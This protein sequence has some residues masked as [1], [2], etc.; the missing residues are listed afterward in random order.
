MG[1][2]MHTRTLALAIL[3]LAT[4][5]PPPHTPLPPTPP[6][7]P[8]PPT[9]TP[10]LTPIP[11]Q[12]MRL[13]AGEGVVSMMILSP[14]QAAALK[15]QHAALTADSGEEG[16]DGEGAQEETAEEEALGPEDNGPWL[17]IVTA[18]G[19]GGRRLGPQ[20]QNRGP[21]RRGWRVSRPHAPSPALVV[22]S[23]PQRRA[24][25]GSLN[26]KASPP[27]AAA[28]PPQLPAGKRVSLARLPLRRRRGSAGNIAIKLD[29]GD[30]VASAHLVLGPDD[31]LLL[32]SRQGL[33]ARTRAAD[34]RCPKGRASRG[35]RLLAL[36]AG[37]EVQTVT[38]V[39][40]L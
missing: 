13:P 19:I 9:P 26:H 16:G 12:G 31:E 36:N 14:S 18:K 28:P 10:N 20:G 7:P 2:R 29:A 17:V 3:E 6:H 39:P 22:G 30:A 1:P 5:T 15:A 35:V 21:P 24:P 27:R 34:V 38:V 8:P 25:R 33:M 23:L 11:L 4:P 40:A 32:A 37:D